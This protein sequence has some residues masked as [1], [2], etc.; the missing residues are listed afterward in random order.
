M[1]GR[2]SWTGPW[3]LHD[4]RWLRSFAFDGPPPGDFVCVVGRDTG[5]A[6]GPD[7]SAVA[8]P[9][10]EGLGPRPPTP[11][12]GNG[13]AAKTETGTGAPASPPTRR[14][15]G[16]G[17]AAVAPP[18]DNDVRPGIQPRATSSNAVG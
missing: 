10:S 15:Q 9:A 2:P 12:A 16:A 11:G 8:L 6:L 17:P 14:W 5:V 7:L 1:T 13:A 3:F 18:S 4:R